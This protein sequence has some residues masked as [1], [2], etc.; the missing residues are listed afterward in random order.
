MIVRS[1][2]LQGAMYTLSILA[3][4]IGTSELAAHQVVIQ[5]WSLVSFAC[6][7]FADVGTMVGGRL[8]GAGHH[9]D[10]VTLTQRLLFLAVAAGTLCGVLLLVFQQAVLD[11]FANGDIPTQQVLDSVWMLTAWM[12]P[13]N[14]LVF[15]SDGILF[16]H[17]AF[18]FIRNLMLL[19]VLGIFV[20]CLALGYTT[21]HSLLALWIAKSL[22][23]CWRCLAAAWFCWRYQSEHTTSASFGRNRGTQEIATEASALLPICS[24]SKNESK[25]CVNE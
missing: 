23:S 11:S 8:L 16:A 7:G 6:D 15:V 22:L 21:A 1:L 19:G 20:P 4:R 5:L 3:S 17:Q 10:V 9:Q 14:A 24:K 2:L 12:Q 18:G 13:I 25:V